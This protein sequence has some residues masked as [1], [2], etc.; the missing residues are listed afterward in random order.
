MS[1]HST[2]KINQLI[3]Q[4]PRGTVFTTVHLEKLGFSRGLVKRYTSSRWLVPLGRG[5]FILKGDKVNWSGGLYALQTQLHLSIHTGGKTALEIKG[6]GHYLS[7]KTRRV[8]LYGSRNHKLPAWFIKYDWGVNVVYSCTKLF[9]EDYTKG[10]SEF[11]E[12]EFA[13]RISSPERAMMEMLYHVPN[14]VSFNEAFLIMEALTSLRPETVMELLQSCNFIKV[15]R[16]F[17]YMAEMHNHPWVEQLNLS[18][19]DFGKGKRVIVP[20][21]KLDKKY[22]ITVPKTHNEVLF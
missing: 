7:E 5:A 3:T 20:N 18:N 21:G 17:M 1:I 13:I 10:F 11:A 14:K 9:P 22:H 16:L 6:Y 4:W 19:V 12:S 15:K 2:Y 8:F